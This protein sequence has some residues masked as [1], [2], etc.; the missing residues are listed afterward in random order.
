VER[1]VAVIAPTPPVASYPSR[2]AWA[3]ALFRCLPLFWWN[4]SLLGQPA[5]LSPAALSW[6]VTR[7]IGMGHEEGRRKLVICHL[8]NPELIAVQ[9]NGSS[10]AGSLLFTSV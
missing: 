4:S 10:V 2:L 5:A 1:G 9:M 6:R 8:L 7:S 3:R